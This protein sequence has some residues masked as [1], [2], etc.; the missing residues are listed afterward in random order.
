MLTVKTEQIFYHP[1]NKRY[2]VTSPKQLLANSSPGRDEII[3]IVGLLGLHGQGDGPSSRSPVR[4]VGLATPLSFGHKSQ[5]A[6]AF[7]Q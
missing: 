4:A 6:L 2:I 3:D 1:M 5:S 7:G